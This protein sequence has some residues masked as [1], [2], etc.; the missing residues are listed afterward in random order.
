MTVNHRLA[1]LKKWADEMAAKNRQINPQTLQKRL[2]QIIDAETFDAH[3]IAKL[4]ERAASERIEV[5]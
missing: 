5:R 3:R 4:K 2:Q 1:K